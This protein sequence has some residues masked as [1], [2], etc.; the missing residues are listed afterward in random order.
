MS[1]DSP[2]YTTEAKNKSSLLTGLLV[3]SLLTAVGFGGYFWLRERHIAR[4]QAQANSNTQA[5]Q[6]PPARV[7]VY[8]DDVMLRG[9]K[10]LIGGTIENISPGQLTD[11][12]VE[13]ELRQR[14]TGV[15]ITKTATVTPLAA[16]A[17]S[18]SRQPGN[19]RVSTAR[20][21]S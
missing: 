6:V 3:A 13:L 4:N 17:S 2:L 11:L 12:Q 16:S 1:F 19:G 15:F 5:K 8:S 7:T 18:A 21:A 20:C 9:D 10:S 14:T